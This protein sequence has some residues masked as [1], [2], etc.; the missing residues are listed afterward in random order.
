MLVGAIPLS[1]PEAREVPRRDADGAREDL[2][3]RA[4]RRVAR[5]RA[6]YALDWVTWR[7][8]VVEGGVARRKFVAGGMGMGS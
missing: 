2:P 7:G 1:N 8:R 4:E 6:V 3:E 5:A